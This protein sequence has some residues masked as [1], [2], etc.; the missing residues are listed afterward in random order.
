MLQSQAR[1]LPGFG[2]AKDNLFGDEGLKALAASACEGALPSLR[3]MYIYG[4]SN[5]G[6][7]WCTAVRYVHPIGLSFQNL[8]RF[9]CRRSCSCQ[10]GSFMSDVCLQQVA[11]QFSTIEYTLHRQG[12]HMFAYMHT[13]NSIH[14]S[15]EANQNVKCP[16]MSRVNPWSAAS[17]TRSCLSQLA[18]WLRLTPHSIYLLVGSGIP[19]LGCTI[20][21]IL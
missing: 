1:Y 13:C 17:L 14:S 16:V 21:A 12:T 4:A 5:L 3:L 6:S 8:T 7:W 9:G 10:W 11:V 15:M 20:R 18:G 2:C 19:W